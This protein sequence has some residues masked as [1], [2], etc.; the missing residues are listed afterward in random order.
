M[1]IG[2]YAV[3]FAAKKLAPRTSLGSLITAA[4]FLDLI[5]PILLL[6]GVEQ[7]VIEPSATPFTPLN[8]TYYPWSHSLLMSAVWGIAFAAL[9]F[10]VTQYRAGAI[11]CGALVPSHWLLDWIVHRPDL[12]LVPWSEARYGLGLWY[13]I[14][15]TLIVELTIFAIGVYLYLKATR[16][17]DRIGSFGL[18]GFLVLT[19][20][21]YG[22]A[23]FGPPPPSVSAIAWTDMG[24]WLFI[25]FA[26]W[27]DQHRA[28]RM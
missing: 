27:V 26:V 28:V 23:V 13:S 20:V 15:L 4:A 19:L 1:I 21:L 12:P 16:I 25:A 22:A 5:W 8:F 10:A 7:V 17:R 18:L 2:H 24:Q 14:P 6:A 9:Y 11:V 3:A